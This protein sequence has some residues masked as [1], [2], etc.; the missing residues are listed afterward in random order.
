MYAATA[1]AF[2]ESFSTEAG[3]HSRLSR[4]TTSVWML[5][6]PFAPYCWK[7]AGAWLMASGA[8]STW[9]DCRAVRNWLLVSGT[10]STSSYASPAFF[11]ARRSTTPWAC[12]W[13]KAS[14]LPLKSRD[15]PDVAAGLGGEEIVRLA[16]DVDRDDFRVVSLV[17]RL[18]RRNPALL[19][20]SRE[21]GAEG[22][23]DIGTGADVLPARHLERQIAQLGQLELELLGARIRGDLQAR[24]GRDLSAS[25]AVEAPWCRR[26]RCC[27]RSRSARRHRPRRRAGR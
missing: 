27:R 19:A 26:R 12:P 2:A 5:R 14:F 13:E 25:G 21:P 7:Y 1:A 10:S 11:N 20:R 9:P 6:A 22:V 16:G 18:D 4:S 17:V 8:M 24:T 3:A 15:R 23:D